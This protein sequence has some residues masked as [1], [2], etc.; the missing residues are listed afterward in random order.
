MEYDKQRAALAAITAGS[1]Q[2]NQGLADTMNAAAGM[3]LSME[4][5][6]KGV[7]K[8]A[9]SLVIFSEINGAAR[10][11][12]SLL[13]AG[14]DKFGIDI[15]G[16]LNIATKAMGMSASQAGALQRELFA[17]GKA[18]GPHMT[19]KVMSE[20]GPAMSTLAAYTN[21]RAIKVFKGLAAQAQL[22]GV[23]ISELL[24]VAAKF[25]TY[26]S[27]AESVGRLNSMLGG[28]YLNSVQMLHASEEDRIKMLRQSIE[29]S[30]KSFGNMS[31]FEKKA[32]AA[33][34]GITDMSKAM[35]ILG[36]SS[37]RLADLEQ[38]AA[39]AG[40]TVDQF[41]AATQATNDVS[42]QFAILM[43]NLAIVIKPVID[44][45]TTITGWFAKLA[46]FSKNTTGKIAILTTT[47]V[48]LRVAFVGLQAA[49][50][51]V[52]TTGIGKKAGGFLS[53]A[54]G[55]GGK[56]GGAGMMA[57][58]KPMLIFAGVLA[59]I[60]LGFA[61]FGA[62]AMVVGPGLEALAKG[63]TAM[64]AALATL[65]FLGALGLIAFL[66][67]F[68]FAAMTAG[69]FMLLAAPG[70][71]A[72]GKAL[73]TFSK[74][75]KEISGIDQT[76]IVR[77]VQVFDSIGRVSPIAA[78]T[79]GFALQQF[80]EAMLTVEASKKEEQTIN[81]VITHNNIQKTGKAFEEAVGK[82]AAVAGK[83]AVVKAIKEGQR[84]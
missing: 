79:A 42:K 46:S 10:Q 48:G 57:M 31:R 68:G 26:D 5:A 76:V 47:I 12:L 61:A 81:V 37:E 19:K 28:D 56:G 21:D 32:V 78:L 51:W 69:M 72:L 33:A 3:N 83:K 64:G 9:S 22:T 67:A 15:S 41:K 74:S 82:I 66:P 73:G 29:L 55:L 11:E 13:T 16:N 75:L 27:A 60:G 45:I 35:Q 54:L 34:A 65:T 39:K 8:L 49:M 40:M 30:G 84:A 80:K 7:M 17:V 4:E 63:I 43:Q 59:L 77:T 18:L 25:D 36:S 20:F 2:Y 52:G 24:S 53:K 58:V 6:A 50:G 70:F 1:K 71:W 23:A 38:K 14:F 62:G 44:V